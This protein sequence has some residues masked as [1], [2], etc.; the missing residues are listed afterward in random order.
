MSSE[1]YERLTPLG[2]GG[3]ASTYRARDRETGA[4]VAVKVLN[5]RTMEGWK[6]YD[7]FQR[8]GEVLRALE[9]PDIP[10]YLDAFS[11]ESEGSCFLVME[12]IEGVPLDSV[13]AGKRSLGTAEL[14]RILRDALGVL[15]YL[16][17]RH[18]PLIHRDI[19]P[20]NLVLRADG[21]VALVDFGGV[22]VALRPEGGSTMV[23]T[24]GYLAPEQ[25]YG[26]ATPRTDL[27]S[28]G[29]TLA[30]LGAGRPGDQ[31]P[32]QGLRVDVAQ[33]LPAGRLREVVQKLVEPDPAHRPLDANET[34]ALLADRELPGPT[35]PVTPPAP[36]VERRHRG[37][38]GRL[39]ALVF[40]LATLAGSVALKLLDVL[41]L[42]I[43]MG[44]ERHAIGRPR[45]QARLRRRSAQVHAVIEDGRH[46]LLALSDAM[47][48]HAL[49]PEGP[50]PKRLKEPK[51]R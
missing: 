50:A 25:L 27:Y 12:L 16:H 36:M 33:C 23:G 13:I 21:R 35:A 32:R 5:L 34:L 46:G 9:H 6:P 48:P 1:R 49:P 29:V 4:I 41:V 8:E 14:A 19:K 51:A 43:F 7:L 37:P 30:A 3:Q 11:E 15:A 22:R 45:R 10:R 42:R 26:E 28:L 31:L 2:S 17:E 24:F 20:A 40:W 18:P 38:V 47:R 39:V 44:A